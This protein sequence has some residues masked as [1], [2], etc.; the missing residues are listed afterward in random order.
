MKWQTPRSTYYPYFFCCFQ[1]SLFTWSHQYRDAMS[2]VDTPIFQVPRSLKQTLFI[3]NSWTPVSKSSVGASHHKIIPSTWSFKQNIILMVLLANSNHVIVQVAQSSTRHQL[4]WNIWF[5]CH[6]CYSLPAPCFIPSFASSILPSWIS[7]ILPSWLSPI[8]PSWLEFAQVTMPD[9]VFI[10]LQLGFYCQYHPLDMVLKLNSLYGPPLAPKLFF[11]YICAILVALKL[12]MT[13]LQNPVYFSIHLCEGIDITV[14]GNVSSFLGIKLQ[15]FVSLATDGNPVH[16]YFTMLS[17]PGI[18]A[19][20]LQSTSLTSCKPDATHAACPP[21][22][23]SLWCSLNWT[24]AFP[25]DFFIR[26]LLIACLYFQPQYLS[27]LPFANVHI[28][29]YA[30]CHIHGASCH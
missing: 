17:Q 26:I 9:I 3:M 22:L 1:T 20:V 2:S 28:F 6:H 24:L 30:P 4:L 29:N 11:E 12:C 23:W 15:T 21:R 10:D 16:S 14:K 8:L 13:I 25:H 19:D 5:S 27:P 7:P 18:I